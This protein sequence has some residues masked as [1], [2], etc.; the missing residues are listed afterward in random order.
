MKRWMAMFFCVTTLVSFL[1]C[2]GSSGAGSCNLDA[3]AVG[4]CVDYLGSLYVTTTIQSANQAACQNGKGIWSGTSCPSANA[5]GFCLVSKGTASELK[6]TFY[7][8]KY[9]SADLARTA[10]TAGVGGNGTSGGEFSTP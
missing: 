4:Y 10:C 3:A 7:K 5:A 9:A 1:H 8:S 2:G 6:V